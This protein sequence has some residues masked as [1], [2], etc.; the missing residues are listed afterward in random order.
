[1]SKGVVGLGVFLAVVGFSVAVLGAG[2]QSFGLMV[3]GVGLVLP[4]AFILYRF[5]A[6]HTSEG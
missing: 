2:Q 5:Y 6:S 4:G 1:M 3:A